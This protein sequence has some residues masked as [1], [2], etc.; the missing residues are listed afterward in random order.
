[1]K[2]QHRIQNWPKYAAADKNECIGMVTT[3]GPASYVELL[4]CVEILRD[5]RNIRN[6]D[7]LESDA[8]SARADRV[9]PAPTHR[10]RTRTHRAPRDSAR[11]VALPPHPTHARRRP[12]YGTR[13]KNLE[14]IEIAEPALGSRARIGV[15]LSARLLNNLVGGGQQMFSLV[16]NGSSNRR[17]EK[18]DAHGTSVWYRFLRVPHLPSASCASASRYE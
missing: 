17:E 7:A 10:R 16:R 18:H 2:P 4:S 9:R 5:A 15:Y 14:A 12:Q 8:R 13:H 11:I 1:M 6:T 3:G